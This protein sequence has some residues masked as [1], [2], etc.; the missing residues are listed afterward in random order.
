M[1]DLSETRPYSYHYRKV[2]GSIICMLCNESFK[3]V[4]AM[5][6]YLQFEHQVKN[7]KEV[8]DEI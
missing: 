2:H 4:W 3:T 7:K 1:G 6:R 8:R 5:E